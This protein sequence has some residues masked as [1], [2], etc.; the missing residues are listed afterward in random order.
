MLEDEAHHKEKLE[1]E[2]AILQSQLLQLSLEA[3]QVSYI[4][5]EQMSQLL[6]SYLSDVL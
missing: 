2:I 4:Q 3:D 1:G 5:N 6:A